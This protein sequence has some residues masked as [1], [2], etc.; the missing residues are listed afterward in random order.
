MQTPC[1]S[2]S[3]E[4]EQSS[5]REWGLLQ[6]QTAASSERPFDPELEKA[7]ERHGPHICQQGT[8]PLPACNVSLN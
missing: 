5:Q 1:H 8:S 6:A 2:H 3:V 4:P 7:L